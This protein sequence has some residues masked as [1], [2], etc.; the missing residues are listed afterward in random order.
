M[1]RFTKL[2]EIMTG[3]GML[4]GPDPA[5]LLPMP[6]PELV[7]VDTATWWELLAQLEDPVAQG[8]AAAALDNGRGFLRARDALRGRVPARIEWKGPHRSPGDEVAPVDLRVDH[9]YLVSCKYLSAIT[10]NASPSHLFDRLLT[11]GHGHRS[12]DWFDEVAAA[13][14]RGLFRDALAHLGWRVT[15][16]PFELPQPERKEIAKLLSGREWPEDLQVGYRELTSAVSERSADRW[17]NTLERSAASESMLW[18]LLRIGSAPYFVLGTNRTERLHLRVGTPWDWRQAF[19]FR[20][21]DVRPGTGGQPRVDWSAHYSDLRTGEDRT[22]D[23]HVEIRWSHGRFSGP[24]EAKVY[25]DT[26]HR[27]VPGYFELR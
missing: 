13:E 19:R 1:S 5:H 11:G 23:G 6:P 8:I 16:A 10:V 9:V 15:A 7:H 2:T 22:V 3:V 18:R 21:L 17:R 27:E 24:P 4:D 14:H 12:G 25:L 20:R 26:P